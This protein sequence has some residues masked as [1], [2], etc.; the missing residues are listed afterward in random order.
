[1]G[2]G[3]TKCRGCAPVGDSLIKRSARAGSAPGTR[4]SRVTKAETLPSHSLCF[5]GDRLQTSVISTRCDVRM[6]C[7]STH[8]NAGEEDKDCREE[9]A[10]LTDEAGHGRVLT[11]PNG[12]FFKGM[13]M[14]AG[15]KGGN[16]GRPVTL[17]QP[18]WEASQQRFLA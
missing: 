10:S 9:S 15:S 4:D 3:V 13:K 14:C 2:R 17:D 6:I 16:Q 11:W 7:A 1:M 12:R 8:N 18:A 5:V